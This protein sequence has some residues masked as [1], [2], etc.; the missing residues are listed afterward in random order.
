MEV[1]SVSPSVEAAVLG[2]RERLREH[3]SVKRQAYKSVLAAKGSGSASSEFPTN[4][5]NISTLK[6]DSSL[7]LQLLA[8]V[9]SSSCPEEVPAECM[10][11][12]FFLDSLATGLM[13]DLQGY[14]H[15]NCLSTTIAVADATVP[16]RAAYGA[17]PVYTE[18]IYRAN[19][20]QEM[21]Q[22]VL[23]KMSPT[24]ELVSLLLND[25]WSDDKGCPDAS[26]AD[27]EVTTAANDVTSKPIASTEVKSLFAELSMNE[28]APGAIADELDLSLPEYLPLPRTAPP[29]SS[30][31]TSTAPRT[32]SRWADTTALPDTAWESLRPHLARRFPFELDHFQKQAIMRLERNESVFVAAHTSA[33]K[34]VCAEYAIA[35]AQ[36][37]GGRAIYTSPIKALS[38]QKYRDFK[39]MFGAGAVG[40]LTGLV[41]YVYTGQVAICVTCA[42]SYSDPY[43]APPFSSSPLE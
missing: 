43:P 10:V 25:D 34:T 14:E 27:N 16:S 28:N 11:F 26:G 42:L 33:G 21:G 2:I 24:G 1:N 12:P 31:P 36:R 20:N 29:P 41:Y 37:E 9:T 15:P 38:N 32:V 4:D 17:A 30:V 5:N 35:M 39:N 7:D 6:D 23:S 22:T 8:W 3:S 18:S 40:L 19:Q 13:P